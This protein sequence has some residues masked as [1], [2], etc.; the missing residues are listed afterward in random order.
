MRRGGDQAGR[1]VRVASR[2]VVGADHEQPGE[3]AL[4][5]GVGLEGH[6]G[7]PGNLGELPFEL[8]EQRLVALRLLARGE[9]VEPAPLVPRE[10]QHLEGGVEL[11]RARAEGDHRRRERQVAALELPDVTQ[12]F[13][14]GAVRV[15]HR[16]SEV[17][18]GSP[19]RLGN[20]RLRFR[21][22]VFHPEG[23]HAV[24]REG[25]HDVREVGEPGGLVERDSDAGG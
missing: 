16:V 10:G 12:H 14:L 23:R 25:G 7:E 2:C 17:R 8:A 1:A 21:R 18:R 24:R 15:E 6:G 3:L 22:Q 19:Q 20:R 9:R 11:H 13:R 5:P 4:R